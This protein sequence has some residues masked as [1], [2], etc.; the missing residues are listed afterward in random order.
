MSVSQKRESMYALVYILWHVIPGIHTL[1]C[2]PWYT[3]SSMH[4]LVYIL[5]Y[6]YLGIHTLVYI[7]QYTCSSV[8][9][10]V[11]IPW[12]MC[13]SI[14]NLIY[15]HQHTYFSIHTL[16]YIPW[17]TYF[18]IHTLVYI[19]WQYTYS[20]SMFIYICSSV[21]DSM[22]TKMVETLSCYRLEQHLQFQYAED[23]SGPC[24]NV[25]CDP[26]SFSWGL[27]LDLS[28]QFS[29]CANGAHLDKQELNTKIGWGEGLVKWKG[30]KSSM[31][32][33]NRQILV[34]K[35]FPPSRDANIPSRE[36]EHKPWIPPIKCNL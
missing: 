12:Y 21:H 16:E 28:S 24:L 17:Y 26:E 20:S 4:I 11:Y 1:V 18:G 35:G 2:I 13:F 15:I 32:L 10:L 33:I 23:T 31:T 22:Y 8:H 9:I 19:P 30:Q 7:L 29:I 6:T 5:Q 27:R 25:G 14:Y 36:A 3:Y 34:L